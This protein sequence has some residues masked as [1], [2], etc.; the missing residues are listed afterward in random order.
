MTSRFQHAVDRFDIVRWATMHVDDVRDNGGRNVYGTCPVCHSAKKLSISRDKKIVR[1]FKCDE[2][3]YGGSTWN[4]RAD[5]V[6]FIML[7][8]RCSRGRALQE[9][10]EHAGP[11]PVLDQDRPALDLSLPDESMLIGTGCGEDHPCRVMLRR[12]GLD[13]FAHKWFMCPTGHYA[14]RL[15]IPVTSFDEDW[16]FEAKSYNGAEPKSLTNLRDGA[17]Y[18]SEKWDTSRDWAVVTESVM[19]AESIGLNAVGLFGSALDENR[20][21]TL[22]R[23]R[24]RGVT[25]LIWFLDGDAFTKQLGI[26]RRWMRSVFRE[27]SNPMPQGPRPE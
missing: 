4:G 12:R 19:D 9:L 25:K 18:V 22:L 21:T 27:P 17:I 15:I 3:G 10:F 8:L 20:L 24:L 2:A 16:G 14:G 23:L 7:V 11:L 13:R 5:L 26:I 1:C 6:R